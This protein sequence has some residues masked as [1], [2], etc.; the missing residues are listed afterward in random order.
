MTPLCRLVSRWRISYRFSPITKILEK[1]FQKSTEFIFSSCSYKN[2]MG[3]DANSLCLSHMYYV[4]KT[5]VNKTFVAPAKQSLYIF[6]YLNR[7]LFCSSVLN[8][9]EMVAL[10]PDL[11][12]VRKVVY[13][14]ENQLVYPVRK[15]QDRDFQYGY[16]QILTWYGITN[17]HTVWQ[18]LC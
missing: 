14:H 12:P 13:F 10:R 1:N 2:Y 7:V 11:A 4:N 9:A 8:L 6:L 16:N 5:L 18:F 3:N 17:S 15:A